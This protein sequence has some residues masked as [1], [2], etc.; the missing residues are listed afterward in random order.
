[1]KDTDDMCIQALCTWA[2]NT[3]VPGLF[4]FRGEWVTPKWCSGPPG[5]CL[6]MPGGI[7]GA[8]DQP[9]V[10]IMQAMY[11]SSYIISTTPH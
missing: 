10:G 11:L 1:M 7:M 5:L 4:L 2:S 8:G 3:Q 9:W 6:V